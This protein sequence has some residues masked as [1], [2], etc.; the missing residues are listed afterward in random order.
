[1]SK[2]QEEFESFWAEVELDLAKAR[3]ADQVIRD[4]PKTR[5]EATDEAVKARLHALER[6]YR[7]QVGDVLQTVARRVGA[8]MLEDDE[9]MQSDY[10]RET[11][12]RHR[13]SALA[14]LLEAV[15]E[16]VVIARWWLTETA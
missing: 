16:Q 1:M 7:P 3:K 11:L 15:D 9:E 5:F 14:R 4:A 6:M 13:G 2:D 12:K 10:V 8:L